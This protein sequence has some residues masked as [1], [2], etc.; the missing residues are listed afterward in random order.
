MTSYIP[1]VSSKPC[2][3]PRILIAAPNINYN[4]TNELC[5]KKWSPAAAKVV[6]HLSD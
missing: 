4:L 6:L 2:W 1:G 5:H 3:K